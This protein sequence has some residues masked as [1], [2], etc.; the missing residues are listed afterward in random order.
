MFKK[1]F[2][3][4]LFILPFLSY[5]QKINRF[6]NK[7]RHGKWIIFTDSTQKQIDNIGRYRKGIQKGTWKY[8]NEKGILVKQDKYRFRKIST[9]YYHPNGKIQKQG[10]AKIVQEEKTLHFFY[11]GDWLVYDT[12]GSLIKKQVYKRGI[13]ISEVDY[14]I[15]AE[16]NI[17][18]SLVLVL[19]NINQTIY[20]YHD[21]VNLAEKVHGK[22]HS[23]IKEQFL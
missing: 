17:N 10:K 12:A 14:K 15:S 3:F 22:L 20:K 8:Y 9:S 2:L 16:K 4:L 13:K 1:C 6:K 11:Y 19:R 18:D 5:S 21:S 7:E 23:N